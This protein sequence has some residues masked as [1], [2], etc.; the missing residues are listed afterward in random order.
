MVFATWGE[1]ANVKRSGGSSGMREVWV[2]YSPLLELNGA[3]TWGLAP[4][5][6]AQLYSIAQSRRKVTYIFFENGFIT[7]FQE[8]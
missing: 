4:T 8:E 6:I 3:S 2:Y 7:S 1:P 5:D